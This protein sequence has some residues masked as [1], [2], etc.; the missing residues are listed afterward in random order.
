M[1]NSKRDANLF[2]LKGE[3]EKH[4]DPILANK[5]NIANVLRNVSKWTNSN[6]LMFC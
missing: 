3:E 5:V 1:K 4:R 2:F 6:S